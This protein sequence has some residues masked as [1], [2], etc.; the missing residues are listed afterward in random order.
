ME[1]K[2]QKT[3]LPLHGANLVMM[4]VL[5]SQATL[6]K[7]VLYLKTNGSRLVISTSLTLLSSKFPFA[8]PKR[9]ERRD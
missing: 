4:E 7:D 5:P 2:A 8:S 1:L 6:L 9:I 3:A